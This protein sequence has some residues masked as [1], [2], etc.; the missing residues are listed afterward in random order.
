M[1][2]KK[3]QTHQTT[4]NIQMMRL[5]PRK[6][7]PNVNIITWSGK[8]TKE[9]KGKQPEE[10]VWVHKVVDKE[11]GF[12]VKK[13]KETFMEEK[14]S[15][16]NAGASTSR[17]QGTC[18]GKPK[19]I[20]TVHEENHSLLASF[21]QTYMKLLRDK[22]LLEGLQELIDHFIGKNKPLPKQR[23]VRKVDKSKKRIVHEMRLTAQI[24][25]FKMD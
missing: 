20:S 15:F 13:V 5:E 2:E 1:Q 6:E 22:K 7:G 17:T 8:T 11:A 24:G 23:V 4:Q 3:T 19:D 9:D 18:T 12:D 14:R 16:T 10:N 21:L 25:E